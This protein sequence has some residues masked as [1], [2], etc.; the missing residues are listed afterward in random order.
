MIF[1]LYYY[2]DKGCAA[3]VF[4]CGTLSRCAVV[5]ARAE[6]VDSY[7]SFAG[8]KNMRITHVIDTHVHADHL[9]GGPALARRV[10]AAYCLNCHGVSHALG[11]HR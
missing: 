9:S 10:G 7:V 11:R 3:Y 5:D 1:R 8:D 4:G 2:F 6:D